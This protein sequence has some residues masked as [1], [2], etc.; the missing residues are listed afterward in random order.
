MMLLEEQVRKEG[1][2]SIAL[3]VF[4]HNEVDRICLMFIFEI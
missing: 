3:H 4:V 2:P 1:L